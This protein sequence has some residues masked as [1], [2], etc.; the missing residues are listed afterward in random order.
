MARIDDPA[1]RNPFGWRLAD[2]ADPATDPLRRL[3]LCDELL[4]CEAEELAHG[5]RHLTI[6]HG[7]PTDVAQ[8]RHL[9]AFY[10]TLRRLADGCSWVRVR[11]DLD[12][13]TVTVRAEG[14]DEQIAPFTSAAESANPGAWLIVASAVPLT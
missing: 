1:I 6:L 14:A 7:D 5:H 11:G 4:V 8:S 10:D 13:V 3:E 2:I 9:S 12:Y